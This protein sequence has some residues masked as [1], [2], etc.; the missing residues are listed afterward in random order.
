M[1]SVFRSLGAAGSMGILALLAPCSADAREKSPAPPPARD[2]VT[3]Q[4]TFRDT[5]FPAETPLRLE[6]LET[7]DTLA[8]AQDRPFRLKLPADTLW[9][10]CFSGLPAAADGDAGR[11]EKCF[12]LRHLGSDTAFAAALG[13]GPALVIAEPAATVAAATPA[14]DSADAGEAGAETYRPE[15]A[16]QLKK[17]LVRAQRAP[18]RSLGKSTVSAK[19]IKRMPGLAEADVI[20]SIQALPGVVASS[21]FSTKIYVRGGGSDQNLILLDK[22][23]V[24]SPVHFFGLFSTFLVEG[25]DKVDF[26]K[27]GF[28]PEFG[29]RLSSVLDIGSRAGGKDTSDSWVKGSSVKIST[30]ASQAHTEGRQGPFRWLLAGR[31]TYIDQVLDFLR[32][33]D[34]TELD[35]PYAFYDLQGNAI[36][37]DGSDRKAM[38]SFY[39]GRDELVFFPFEVE[40]G[41]TVIPVNLHWR[42]SPRLDTR[43]TASYS[44]FSQSFGLTGIFSLYNRIATWNLTHI[45]EYT[46]LADHR[47]SFGG[48]FNFMETIFA[49]NQEVARLQLRDL[50]KFFI[51]NLFV[52]DKYSRGDGEWTAGARLSQSS[53]LNR[54]Y[55]EPRLSYRHKLPLGQTLDLHLGYYVQYVNSISFQDQENLNEFYYPAKE[56]AYRTVN[57]TTSLLFSTGYGLEKL[58]GQLDISLESYYKTLNHL[59]V[60]APDELPDSLRTRIDI[61]L[62]DYFKEA[63]GYSFGS[64]VSVRRPEGIV[65]GGFSYSYGTSVTLEDNHDEAYFPRWHQPH[66]FKADLALNWRGKDGIWNTKKPGRYFRSSTQLKYA[67]GLPFTEEIGYMQA[68]LLDQS[69]GRG[70]GGPNPEFQ[71]DINTIRGNR[72]AAFVPAYLRWDAKLVDWGREGKW[73]FS[74]T[75]LNLTDH[76]NIFLYTYERR[77]NPPERIEITQ[78][79]FFPM[80]VNYEYTF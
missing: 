17:V 37:E 26:Y 7:G 69:P 66:S 51:N 57:P 16:V 6:V 59:L 56:V 61:S 3:F 64:E 32:S 19:L 53:R 24:Y 9:N 41:N 20:R 54:P 34:A 12:E 18:K 67:T 27:G 43:T 2:S 1:S 25:I 72:N 52:Q 33:V 15:D 44:L 4:G 21:D 11:I 60:F 75:I 35:L 5:S 78:F 38:A 50:T 79:P 58:F 39:Q 74:W 23:V 62:G 47:L 13:E 73:N 68:H 40:W 31:R 30:F 45:Q 36:Y 63:N 65:F 55:L 70:A 48:D 46:G 77:S 49:N 14:Q 28:P 80:L 71:G 42:L 8:V 10:L 29:N 22:A 76:K